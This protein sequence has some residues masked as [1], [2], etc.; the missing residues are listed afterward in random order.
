MAG[1]ATP[2]PSRLGSDSLTERMWSLESCYLNAD[3]K[4][5]F[6]WVLIATLLT[7]KGNG[8]NDDEV[9][10]EKL[11]VSQVAENLKYQKITQRQINGSIISA[12]TR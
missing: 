6:F 7:C 9:N 8:E 3:R 10:E 5:K 4:K 1:D 2:A 12:D 11:E